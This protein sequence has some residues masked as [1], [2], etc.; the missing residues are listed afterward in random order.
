MFYRLYREV[1]EVIPSFT[2]KVM[3]ISGRNPYL[4]FQC[5]MCTA[6][7]PVSEVMD[8]LPHQIVRL[9]QLGDES[10][11]N[12]RA[13]WDCISC[14]ACVDRCPRN[15]G[16]GIIFE[17]LRSIVLRKGVDAIDYSKLIEIEKAPSMAL[18]ALSR[19]QTG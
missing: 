15:V 7:C 17:A 19:K 3:E 13:I 2:G 10:V 1:N 4:C 8:I 6:V 9:V 11:L 5:G 14:M 18:V 16:P 12:Y